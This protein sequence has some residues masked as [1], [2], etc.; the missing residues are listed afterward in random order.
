MLPKQTQKAQGY[1]QSKH[2]ETVQ[3]SWVQHVV[4]HSFYTEKNLKNVYKC[5]MRINYLINLDNWRC[6]AIH[7]VSTVQNLSI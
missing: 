5:L 3:T 2:A 6:A 1:L 4:C 7:T